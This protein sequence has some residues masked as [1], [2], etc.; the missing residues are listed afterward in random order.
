MNYNLRKNIINRGENINN[1]LDKIG[2]NNSE[3][4]SVNEDTQTIRSNGNQYE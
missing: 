4:S 2:E 3:S 1:L